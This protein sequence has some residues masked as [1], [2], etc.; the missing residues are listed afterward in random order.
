[1]VLDFGSITGIPHEDYKNHSLNITIVLV[2]SVV[3]LLY[4]AFF[5]MIPSQDTG[6]QQ[7]QSLLWIVVGAVFIAVVALNGAVYFYDVDVKAS[8]K[9]FFTASPLIDVMVS[10]GG[11]DGATGPTG[12]EGS[13]G[14]G[15]NPGDGPPVPE[16]PWTEEV[17]HVRGN[18]FTYDEA[19]S[20]CKAYGGRLA[21]VKEIEDSY[22]NG[23]DWCEYGW[24]EDQLALY[25]TQY[26]KWQTLQAIK[27]R[28]HDC[29]RPGVNGGYIDNPDIRF[30]VNCYGHKPE[31]TRSEAAAME[32]LRNQP[33][34]NP[35]P[36][37]EL[38]RAKVP[39]LKVSPFN[40]EQWSVIS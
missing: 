6:P 1:M 16:I 19:R 23:G 27:G 17:F 18:Q 7:G 12:S 20:V 3:V 35:D 39:Y 29:G 31:I 36:E 9:D 28:K 5:A 30:G 14:S 11:L 34:A 8:I 2:I 10:P 25:P 32:K 40:K 15:T 4:Y 26:S 24:S 37:S 21:T 13:E 38:W 33:Q 22:N